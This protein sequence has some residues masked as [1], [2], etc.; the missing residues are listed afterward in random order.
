MLELVDEQIENAIVPSLKVSCAE[1]F[2]HE[3]IAPTL[4][5]CD[6]NDP[7]DAVH[8][9]EAEFKVL[10]ASSVDDTVNVERYLMYR[11]LETLLPVDKV[12]FV[13]DV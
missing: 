9:K 3:L 12:I 11:L 10:S 8:W 7:E 13:H 6:L 5:I 2:P 4:W 1:K